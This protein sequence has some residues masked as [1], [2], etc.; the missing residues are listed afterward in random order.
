ME[1]GRFRVHVYV[2]QFKNL[3]VNISQIVEMKPPKANGHDASF[4]H[5]SGQILDKNAETYEISM[6]APNYL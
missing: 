2:T 5:T 6:M 1:L 4:V 3:A